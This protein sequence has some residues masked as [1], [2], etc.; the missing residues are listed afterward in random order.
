MRVTLVNP[1][2]TTDIET[3]SAIGLKAP[4]LGL[5]Y[6]G[7]VLEKEAVDV[8]IIDAAV[9]EM[10][11]KRLGEM[12]QKSNP[13]VVGVTSTTPTICDALKVVII[14]KRMCPKA[15]TMRGGCHITF[16]PLGTM[17]FCP[18]LDIGILGE[19][20]STVVELIHALE[21]GRALDDLDGLV[22]RKGDALF[23]NRP[24]ALIQDLDRVP[25]PARHLLPM[26]RYSVFGENMAESSLMTSRG[27]PFQCTFCSSSLMY[28][29]Y[30][31]P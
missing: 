19:E 14:S 23:K 12:L 10:S 21:C 20:E 28:G 18:Q 11:H 4:P 26:D 1:P 8:T 15:T 17:A 25:F 16:M 27:C 3:V 29:D 13:D 5:A 7:A 6:I 22:Y 31:H 30:S 24:R 2:N 9:N